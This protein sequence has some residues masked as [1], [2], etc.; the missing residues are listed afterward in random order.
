MKAGRGRMAMRWCGEGDGGRAKT[1]RLLR[2]Y[3]SPSVYSKEMG[4]LVFTLGYVSPVHST[5]IADA[6]GRW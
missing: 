3:E 1:N 6:K 4:G 5:N 2:V